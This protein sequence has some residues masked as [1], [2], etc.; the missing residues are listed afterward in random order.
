MTR[1]RSS[2][3]RGRHVL[4]SQSARRTGLRIT[5]GRIA[6]GAVAVLTGVVL[7]AATAAGSYA[8]LNSTAAVGTSGATVA[9]GTSAITL[10]SGSG[11]PTSNLTLP[12]TVWNRMLPGDV[13][14][15]TITVTN[16]GDTALAGSVRL[17]ATSSPWEIRVDLGAC[18]SG[19]IAGGALG[20]TSSA[21]ATIPAGASA[22]LCIQATL[23]T[24]APSNTQGTSPAMTLIVDGVQVP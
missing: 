22:T 5:P 23:P 12:N 7:A 4:E 20:T 21:S 24:S 13:V 8:Y 10:Q 2:A 9:A 16:S 6:A 14:G 11:V 17:A 19:Q 18:P 15:Q 3:R 1:M